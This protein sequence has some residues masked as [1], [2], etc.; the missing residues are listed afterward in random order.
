LDADRAG[1]FEGIVDPHPR[2][3]AGSLPH[4]TPADQK[5]L[6]A[7]ERAAPAACSTALRRPLELLLPV[8]QCA[9][10]EDAKREI[11]G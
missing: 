10:N 3:R 1:I 8:V 7:P 4:P 11:H 9:H 5:S 6:S 2:H